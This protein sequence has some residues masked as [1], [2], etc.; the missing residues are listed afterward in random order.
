MEKI[1]YKVYKKPTD[2]LKLAQG[3]NVIR[4]VSDGF[5]AT[6]YGMR[7]GDRWVRFGESI[8]DKTLQTAKEKGYT[9][10]IKAARRWVWIGLNRASG[11]IGILEVGPTVGD[12]ICQI[13]QEKECDPKDI[14]LL[15][16]KDGEGFNTKYQI[17][18]M[19]ESK[20]IPKTLADKIE[21]EK[22]YLLNKYYS[23]YE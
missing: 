22:R 8:P 18:S 10:S 2:F 19:K 6:V 17:S 1:N 13:A 14:D 7:T 16:K 5:I 20:P 3:D 11:H 4:I 23:L 21:S 9:D 12:T 15:V